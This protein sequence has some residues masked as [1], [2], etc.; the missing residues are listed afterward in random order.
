MVE[1]LKV[2]I[3]G[4]Q[5]K[6]ALQVRLNGINQDTVEQYA[7]AVQEG[8]VFPPLVVFKVEDGTYV[9]VDGYHR[10]EALRRLQ[11]EEAT[12]EVHTGTFDE[13]LDYA[14][15]TSNRK[16]GQRLSRADLW[17]LVEAVVTDPRHMH[18]SDQLLAKLC[19]C[20][21]PT[22]AAARERVGVKPESKLGADGKVRVVAP[23]E[24][25]AR[26]NL[27]H[28]PSGPGAPA[29]GGEGELTRLLME[30][31]KDHL[32]DLSVSVSKLG[33]RK[34]LAEQ[35][36]TLRGAVRVLEEAVENLE[37]ARS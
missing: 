27:G 33:E 30:R 36:A 22:V 24:G 17:S 37:G 14:R 18:K 21:A 4:I 20:S 7:V 2:Q 35:A 34:G 6:K 19:G 1:T 10:Y 3:K 31:L 9:L 12:V 23:D 25:V 15:F 28:P 29:D 13:A 26:V 8:D 32:T 11:F 16:N 5:R